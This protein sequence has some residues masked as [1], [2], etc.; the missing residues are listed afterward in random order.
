MYEK[1]LRCCNAFLMEIITVFC[2]GGDV[3]NLDPEVFEILMGYVTATQSAAE[4]REFS[5]FPEFGADSSPMVRSFVLQ[6]LIN[7]RCVPL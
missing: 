4:T 2:F 3:P 5:P 1:F 7:S 6:Q